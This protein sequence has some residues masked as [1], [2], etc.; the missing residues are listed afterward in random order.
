MLQNPDYM[1]DNF[2]I[3]IETMHLPDRGQNQNVSELLENYKVCFYV[4]GLFT[5]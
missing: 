3:K 5:W 1:K 4:F 2:Y